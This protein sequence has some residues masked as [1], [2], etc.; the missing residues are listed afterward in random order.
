MC[1]FLMFLA[2]VLPGYFEA[3]GDFGVG[4]NG[5]ADVFTYSRCFTEGV[6]REGSVLGGLDFCVGWLNCAV[7]LLDFIYEKEERSRGRFTFRKGKA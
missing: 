3:C 4:V 6:S 5:I 2:V 1:G 7:F